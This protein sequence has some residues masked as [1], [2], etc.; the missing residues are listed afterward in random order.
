MKLIGDALSPYAAR[1][2][3]AAHYKQVDLPCEPAAG[4][5]RSAEH[6]A[7]NPIGKVPVLIDG[8]LV[9]PESDVIVGYLE[10]R[11]PTPTLFPGDAAQRANARLVTRLLDTYSAPSF[12]PFV[13]NDAPAIAVA[14]QRIGDA[15]RYIDHFRID[16]AYASGD[17]F[18]IADC[19]LIPFFHTFEG[20]QTRSQGLF[21]TYDLV[22]RH[23]RL[24]AWWQRAKASEIGLF[25]AHAID[26]AVD[27]FLRGLANR[28]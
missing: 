11:F 26:E 22:L 6:L 19:A 28:T 5:P 20:L 7:R 3:I 2:L 9:L 8:S 17:A 21:T 23:P 14:M 4:G 10:D 1:V 27:A 15:L 18:S 13:Q 16:G 12:G 24:E 25:A